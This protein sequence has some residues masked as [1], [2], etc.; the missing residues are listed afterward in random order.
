MPNI[1]YLITGIIKSDDEIISYVVHENK[2]DNFKKL[3]PGKA[4]SKQHVIDLI[5]IPSVIA[6]AKWDY[7]KGIWQVGKTV[8]L[9]SIKNIVS[10]TTLFGGKFSSK[11]IDNL[12]DVGTW[13]KPNK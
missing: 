13:S 6:I 10:L 8:K 7:K 2:Y 3:E 1:N 12:I 4:L 5:R 11:E 9:F